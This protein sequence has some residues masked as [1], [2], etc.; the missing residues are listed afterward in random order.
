MIDNRLKRM[1]LTPALVLCAGAACVPAAVLAADM[2]MAMPEPTAAGVLAH[3]KKQDY[4]KNWKYFP[5]K[6]ALYKGQAPHGAFLT[7][8]VNETA[9]GA[10]ENKAKTLPHGSILVKENYTPEKK[11]AA[12]T[13]MYKASGYNPEHGDW[14]WLKETAAGKVQASG[15]VASCQACHD[16]SKRDYIMTPLP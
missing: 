2:G 13:V 10:L 9:R 3:L 1:T 14:F 8:Y 11:L 7:T 6:Q 4:R 5:G 15:K 12:V 16:Q